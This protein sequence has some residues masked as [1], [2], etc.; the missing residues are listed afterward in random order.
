MGRRCTPTGEY[1]SI[2]IVILLHVTSIYLI[3]LIHVSF[4]CP[5]PYQA[6]EEEL[7][8]KQQDIVSPVYYEIHIEVYILD[9]AIS[10]RINW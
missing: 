3:D 9:R 6:E 5:Q 7:I 8:S 2:Y 4:E 1:I 10:L